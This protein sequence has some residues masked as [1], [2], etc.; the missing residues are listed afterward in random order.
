MLFYDGKVHKL[1]RVS[2]AIPQKD[3]RDRF[4]EPWQ[5]TSNDQRIEMRFE[6]VLDR[7]S[8]TDALLLKSDQHQVFG[9]FSGTAVLDDGQK[10]TLDHAM[11]FAEKVFN[12]W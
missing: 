10:I 8:L 9:R 7:A 1:D 3:G 4:L 5:I 12:R 6:P 2:F 11:G